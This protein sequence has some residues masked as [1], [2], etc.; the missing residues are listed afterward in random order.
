LARQVAKA[1]PEVRAA[2]Q[3]ATRSTGGGA[4]GA[5][6]RAA[7]SGA[8]AD[9]AFARIA[10]KLDRE[11]KAMIKE[12]TPQTAKEAARAAAAKPR[13]TKKHKLLGKLAST[14]R[15]TV[16]RGELEVFSI[17]PWAGVHNAGGTNGKGAPIPPRTF[18][19]LEPEDGDKLAAL[20]A[21]HITSRQ[22]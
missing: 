13:A 11:M 7:S 1:A 14:I 19:E 22:R 6:L 21:D 2:L 16:G 5:A 9:K 15:A 20:I 10:K 3:S 8:I 4:I 18:L 17:V 12:G